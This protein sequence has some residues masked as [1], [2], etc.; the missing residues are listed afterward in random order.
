MR[1]A[2]ARQLSGATD[3]STV[4]ALCDA[5]D[6]ETDSPWGDSAAASVIDTLVR[7][8]ATGRAVEQCLARPL[9]KPWTWSSSDHGDMIRK[10]G[11]EQVSS[12]LLAVGGPEALF[13]ALF[14]VIDDPLAATRNNA[15]GELPQ[16]AYSIRHRGSP[17]MTSTVKIT[18]PALDMLLTRLGL[19][20]RGPDKRA[21][22]DAHNALR[23]LD[24][25]R[26][27]EILRQFG[28]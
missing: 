21:R 23:K 12:A 18:E 13:R 6:R 3:E 16:I 22:D 4:Q 26:A 1:R 7:S 20:L 5:L 8:G 27:N 25:G 17:S 2:A 24:S 10:P 28:G 19:L 14:A 15:T 9:G 11:W